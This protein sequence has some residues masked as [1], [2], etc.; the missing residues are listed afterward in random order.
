M[1]ETIVIVGVILP[2]AFSIAT[3]I[4]LLWT[5]WS[6]SDRCCRQLEAM[7][8]EYRRAD[9]ELLESPTDAEDSA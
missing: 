6:R 9:T 7:L 5:G 8:D 4:A 1:F 2:V 3:V